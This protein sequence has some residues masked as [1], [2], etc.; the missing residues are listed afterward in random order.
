M[1]ILSAAYRSVAAALAIFA[2]LMLV[3]M[4]IGIGAEAILRTLGLG[5]IRGIVDFSEY[6]LFNIAILAS[7]WILIRNGHIAINLVTAHLTNITARAVDLTAN[8]LG[9]VVSATIAFYGWRIFTVSFARGEHIFQELIIPDWWLQ[10]QV[11]TAFALLTVEFALRTLRPPHKD[12][13]TMSE[14]A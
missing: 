1:S 10:W 4:T 13:D 2:G 14:G 9:L 12:P 3:L 5:L 7:P 6:S 11:P 8:L